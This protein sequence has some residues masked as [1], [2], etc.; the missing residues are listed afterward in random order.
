MS[1]FW[2]RSTFVTWQCLA[3]FPILA[4]N[5]AETL[6][7][8]GFVSAYEDCTNR[9]P[10]VIAQYRHH[11]HHPHQKRKR[12]REVSI[13][14]N[15]YNKT[16]TSSTKAWDGHTFGIFLLNVSSQTIEADQWLHKVSIDTRC[17]TQAT[18]AVLV[19]GRSL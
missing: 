17:A 19:S 3:Y 6:S 16:R 13:F 14:W 11:H 12:K 9:K 1:L 18:S 7:N 2:I 10:S 5:K 15:V 8:S 4:M